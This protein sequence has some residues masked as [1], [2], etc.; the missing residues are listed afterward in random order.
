MWWWWNF[1]SSKKSKFILLYKNLHVGA[2][3]I[4][5]QD[6]L[7]IGADLAVPNGGLLLVINMLIVL[8]GT[9]K[10]FEVLSRKELAQPFGLKDLA[11]TLK[12]YVKEQNYK[13]K[14]MGVLN[15]NEDSFLKIVDL[16]FCASLKLKN[17]RRW[18]K[19]YRYWC[20][21]SSRPG[22]LPVSEDIELERLKDIVQTIY[23]INI[24][25]KLIFNWFLF[26]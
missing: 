19:Y 3:N 5:K 15:A 6:A 24:M 7:S 23:K 10:H 11:K 26:S 2:A 14:I 17:D 4:L 25:K 18:C 8:I 1:N 20:S 13:T 21:F 22:S 12:D 16:R 9:T